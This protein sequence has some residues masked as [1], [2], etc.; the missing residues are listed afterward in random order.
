MMKIGWLAA[1]HSLHMGVLHSN[2]GILHSNTDILHSITCKL[3]SYIWALLRE[4][5]SL[6]FPTKQVSNQS[7]QFKPCRMPTKTNHFKF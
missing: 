4:N 1:V 5:M 7:P 6:G 2:I 3:H